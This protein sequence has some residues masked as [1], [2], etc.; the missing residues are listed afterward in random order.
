[1]V[2]RKSYSLVFCDQYCILFC[3]ASWFTV[4]TLYWYL[5][6]VWHLVNE[7]EII[8]SDNFI[9]AWCVD[10]TAAWGLQVH[11]SYNQ[12]YWHSSTSSQFSNAACCYA[13]NTKPV[14]VNN[15]CLMLFPV[16]VQRVKECYFCRT[17]YCYVTVELWV[18][19]IPDIYSL[20]SCQV[21]SKFF[22]VWSS[23]WGH[24]CIY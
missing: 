13:G 18:G 8:Y 15:S 19:K 24:I 20:K 9:I 17:N 10:F 6:C 23:F 14:T 5:Q 3:D 1:M 7:Y 4:L 2:L 11:G 16:T 21:S 12:W 22:K